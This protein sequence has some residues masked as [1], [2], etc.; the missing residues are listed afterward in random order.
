[1][2][3]A[4]EVDA[5]GEEQ[6]PADNNHP[7]CHEKGERIAIA[8]FA[9]QRNETDG[10]GEEKERRRGERD[11]GERA[12]RVAGVDIGAAQE[13]IARVSRQRID[14]MAPQIRPGDEEDD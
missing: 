3:D 9:Q 11:H 12:G 10:E 14:G 8:D 4:V 1:M 7:A 13:Q 5:R 2:A 6:A